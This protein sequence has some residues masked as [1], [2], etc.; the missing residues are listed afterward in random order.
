MDIVKLITL[1]KELNTKSHFLNEL[2][3]KMDS[4]SATTHNPI[5]W[6][7]FKYPTR[8][9]RRNQKKNSQPSFTNDKGIEFFKIKNQINI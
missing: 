4:V 3:E 1:V 5:F 7:D 9:Q 8:R 2:Q 6:L